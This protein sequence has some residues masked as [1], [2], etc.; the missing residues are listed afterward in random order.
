MTPAA[1]RYTRESLEARISLAEKRLKGLKSRLGGLQ[2]QC[3]HVN[4]KE[5]YT[6]RR[7]PD[8]GF[9]ND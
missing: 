9:W 5:G 8:C 7:C 3:R 6:S 1:I 2:E 4:M